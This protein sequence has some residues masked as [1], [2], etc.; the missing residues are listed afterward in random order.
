MVA[1]GAASLVALSPL[2]F[3]GEKAENSY[4]ETKTSYDLD[5]TSGSYNDV[6]KGHNGENVADKSANGLLNISGNNLNVSPQTC[7][8]GPAANGNSL[9]G[10]ALGLFSEDT[11]ATHKSGSD[12]SV[13][14]T[15]ASDNGDDLSQDADGQKAKDHK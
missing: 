11:E 8:G 6:Q 9:L 1:A 13:D 14:C 12:N 7:V 10:G 2:A 15:N 5:K 3:A 4:N